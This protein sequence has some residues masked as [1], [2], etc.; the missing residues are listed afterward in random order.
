MRRR[1]FLLLLL[2][3]VAAFGSARRPVATLEPA[4][5]GGRFLMG[6]DPGAGADRSAVSVW[7]GRLGRWRLLRFRSTAP[8]LPLR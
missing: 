1:A 6:V 5:G 3:P 7:D 4:A 8:P 2:A